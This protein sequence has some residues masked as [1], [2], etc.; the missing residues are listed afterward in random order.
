MQRQKDNLT[1]PPAEKQAIESSQAGVETWKYKAKN[2]L[3]YYPEGERAVWAAWVGCVSESALQVGVSVLPC[4]FG[5][6]GVLS[7]LGTGG[8]VC[9]VSEGVRPSPASFSFRSVETEVG[10]VLLFSRE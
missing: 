4:I 8:S 9:E 10:S 3:M 7:W 2:S 1:L 5:F 6:R